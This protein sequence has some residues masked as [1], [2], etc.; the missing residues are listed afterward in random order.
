MKLIFLESFAKST[1]SL[2]WHNELNGFRIHALARKLIIFKY[3]AETQKRVY[4]WN[5][6]LFVKFRGTSFERKLS[7]DVI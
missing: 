3:L 4:K 2:A 7:E 6:L 5:S 1:L